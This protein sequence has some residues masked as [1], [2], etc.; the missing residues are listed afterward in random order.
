MRI[1]TVKSQPLDRQSTLEIEP[2]RMRYKTHKNARRWIAIGS[3]WCIFRLF[4]LDRYNSSWSTAE[5]KMWSD[6]SDYATYPH[7]LSDDQRL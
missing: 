5:I 3:S 4:N 1:V 7:H 6:E 2:R